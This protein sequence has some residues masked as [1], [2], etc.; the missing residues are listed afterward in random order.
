MKIEHRWEISNLVKRVSEDWTS[1]TGPVIYASGTDVRWK[2]RMVPDCGGYLCIEVKQVDHLSSG[3]SSTRQ[4]SL[5]VCICDAANSRVYGVCGFRE[6]PAGFDEVGN[7]LRWKLIKSDVVLE[8]R[9]RYLPGGKL[10]VLCTLHYLQPD[11]YTDAADQLKAPV[12][13]VPPPEMSSG[14]GK[15]LTEGRFSDFTVV[16]DGR[17]FS[18]H[19]AILA[20]RSEVF[21]TMFEL[22]MAEKRDD[23]VVIEDLSADAVSDLLTFIYTDSAPNIKE[24]AQELLVAAEK[25]NIPRLKAVCEEELA[26][27]LDIDNVIDRLLQSETYQAFYLK[28]AALHWITKHAPDV[29]NTTSWK[30]LCEHRPELVFVICGQFASYIKMLK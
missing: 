17:E 25:Y 11:T 26:K 2:L 7:G 18:A 13:V 6:V 22:D 9:A 3:I 14:M 19:R 10:I 15:V 29:V 21:R 27:S 20:Q 16:A 30:Y 8:N 12:L 28:D 5:G 4:V 24:I 23:H 1:I